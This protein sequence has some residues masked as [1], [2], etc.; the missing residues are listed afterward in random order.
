MAA[1]SPATTGLMFALE[2]LI[3]RLSQDGSLDRNRYVSDLKL[4]YN[5]LN[6]EQADA[7]SGRA[8]HTLVRHLER[9]SG[10]KP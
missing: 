10:K 6:P 4:G 2:L 8:L 7:E 1:K 5:S 3:E 9:G